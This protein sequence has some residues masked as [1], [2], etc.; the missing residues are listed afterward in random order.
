[1]KYRVSHTTTYSYSD[2]V[3]LGHNL[4]HLL[5]RAF[6]RQWRLNSRL[7]IKPV[8]GS[9]ETWTDYFGNLASSFTLEEE[10]RELTISAVSEVLVLGMLNP[11]PAATPEWDAVRAMLSNGAERTNVDKVP[12]LLDSPFV[13]RHE[14]LRRYAADSFSPGRPLL[15]AALDLT[16]RIHHEF[17]YDTTATGVN[18]PVME[19]YQKRRG[20]CQDFAHLEIACLRSLGLAARYVSG[21]LLTDPPPGRPRL[22]GADAS[23]A[24]LSVFCPTL[25][26]IDLDP[27]NNQMPAFRHI[28]L[29]WGRD[30]GDV[31]PIKGVVLG[32]GSHIVH[33]AVDV[34]TLGELEDE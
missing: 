28:T 7:S 21:Y 24:W 18:T 8:P 6:D 11:S 13:P 5:P 29:A 4:L 27:T 25:G 1:M 23:H 22:V 10:H 15:E 2:P 26:W 33:V 32:G 34:A 14:T 3:S 19:T 17:K 9:V 31:S 30:Y 12:F 20:V 16:G